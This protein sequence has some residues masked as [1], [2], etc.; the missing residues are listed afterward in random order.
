M[1]SIVKA[2]FKLLAL[3]VRVTLKTAV[4]IALW[5]VRFVV[6]L[7]FVIASM[8]VRMII[9]ALIPIVVIGVIVWLLVT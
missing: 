7:P 8:V 2:P 3:L 9:L 6:R 5:P 1:T 4:G